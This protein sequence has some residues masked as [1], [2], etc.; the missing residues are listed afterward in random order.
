MLNLFSR[1]K[2]NTD[3]R[4]ETKSDFEIED[5]DDVEQGKI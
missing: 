2:N 1:K 5:N 4:T 3:E